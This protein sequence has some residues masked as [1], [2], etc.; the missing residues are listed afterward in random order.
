MALSAKEAVQSASSYM[1]DVYGALEGLLVEEL[2]HDEPSR[3]WKVTMGFWQKIPPKSEPLSALAM[4]QP[5]LWKRA[6]KELTI[7]DLDG[8]VK[9]M[10]IRI[11]P[12]APKE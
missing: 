5:A 1:T 11:V 9:A 10:K 12:A 2:E 4:M 8:S 3:I 7:S 6:Y